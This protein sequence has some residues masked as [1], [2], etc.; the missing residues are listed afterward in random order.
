MNTPNQY[1]VGLAQD[2]DNM[3]TDIG[4]YI[5]VYNRKNDLSYEAQETNDESPD[6]EDNPYNQY[7][8]PYEEIAYLQE[9]DTKH[10]MVHS[11]QLN[12]GDVRVVLK[13]NSE[14]K[15]EAL[16]QDNNVQYK[17][18]KL[19]RVGGMTNSVPIWIIA[20]G[21]KLPFR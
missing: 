16:I 9:L 15:E 10:E 1:D 14:V 2:F 5:T 21:Q 6:G 12:V 13:A 20:W 17:V 7:E 19:T 4:H 18:I 11:G 8:E 3:T